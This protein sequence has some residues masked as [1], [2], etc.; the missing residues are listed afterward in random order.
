MDEKARFIQN[1]DLLWKFGIIFRNG[2]RNNKTDCESDI[3][4]IHIPSKEVKRFRGSFWDS[5]YIDD[6][7]EW[8]V[9]HPMENK[10]ISVEEFRYWKEKNIVDLLRF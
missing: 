9:K 8:V 10:K 6:I 3:V 1:R 5:K 7:Y 4:F 2:P